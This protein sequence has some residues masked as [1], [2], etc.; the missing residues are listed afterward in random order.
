MMMPPYKRSILK[1]RMTVKAMATYLLENLVT[2]LPSSSVSTLS[3]TRPVNKHIKKE[4][5]ND[6]VAMYMPSCTQAC[7]APF[8]SV[9]SSAYILV[10]TKR[11]ESIGAK[12][13]VAFDASRAAK[14]RCV[15]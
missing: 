2:T 7:G 14:A 6:H 12:A 5:S 3:M 1:Y 13:R 15:V 9:I 10:V 8:L 4:I 11:I